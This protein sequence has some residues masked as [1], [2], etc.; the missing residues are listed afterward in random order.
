M[1]GTVL[2]TLCSIC[3]TE[4]P[5]YK[6][7]RCLARTCSL[8][9]IQK[10]KARAD[11]DGLR[12]PRAFMPISQLKT[13]AGVDHDFNFLR[14]IERARERAEKDVV[15][16]RQL[17]SEKELRPKNEDKVFQ[18]VWYGDE[19]HHVPTQSHSYK[20]HGQPQEGPA[21]SGLDKHLRRRVRYLDIEVVTM[22][23]GMARQ[24]E[25]KTA[26]NKRTQSI[27]WQVEWLVYRA[28]DL[29][30]PPQQ[31]DDQPLRVLRKTLEGTP[32]H[33]ALASTLDWHRGQLDRQSRTQPDDPTETD[34]EAD[35]P[36]SPPNPKRRKITHHAKK[37]R[38]TPTTT[39]DP[40]TSTWPAA[41]YPSQYP[42]TTAWCSTTT[43]P[44]VETTLEEKLQTWRFYLRKA[45]KDDAQ[46]TKTLIP[47]AS[48]ETLS[49]ALAGR[50][51]VEFP[52]IVAVP[53]GDGRGVPAGYAVGSGGERRQRERKDGGGVDGAANGGGEGKN[54]NSNNNRKRAF[55]GGFKGQERG[56]QRWAASPGNMY[57][58]GGKRVKFDGG[59]R[60]APPTRA[61]QQPQSEAE[62]GEV[63]SDGGDVMG[64]VDGGVI[65]GDVD[66]EASSIMLGRE[67]ED[68]EIR[69]EPEDG[70]PRGGLVDYGSSDE[71]D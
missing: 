49:S 43:S 67:E 3:H 22:P 10:H 39:Q 66:W 30:S 33:A 40:S 7:P 53:S 70:R 34:N 19:L 12:N 62:E 46:K 1:S 2:S 37:K 26:W 28:S 32:L 38:P 61:E 58:R 57:G 69:E 51:V 60:P 31:D 23:K 13:A 11:C 5:K 71:S 44:H 65:A 24:R 41:P 20:K 54:N 55:E 27:N 15:E 16:A 18:K 14:S 50:T 52:T 21:F 4:P 48:A 36:S 17:L 56:Q 29:G 45:V 59:R 25:N 64:E 68:G 42:L 8:S 6:C 63:D 9:C 47:L 35:D